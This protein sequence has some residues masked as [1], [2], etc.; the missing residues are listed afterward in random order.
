M[1]LEYLI[2]TL[3]LI[4]LV[5]IPLNFIYAV[6]GYN[7]ASGFIYLWLCLIGFLI[8][9]L[10]K[11]KTKIIILP[12]II[13]FLPL[14]TANSLSELIYLFIYCIMTLF[15][16]LRGMEGIR[17]DTELDLFSKGLYIC[18]ATCA[19]S[20]ITGKLSVF[21]TYSA[22]YV[23][24]YLVSSILLLRNL[25]FMEYNKDSRE[26]RRINNRYSI[27]IVI[28]SAVLSISY[29]REFVIN[30]IKRSYIYLVDLFMYLF[31]WLFL[32]IGYL[33]TTISNFIRALLEKL[34]VVY[35]ESDISILPEMDF[36]KKDEREALAY[37]LI[38]NQIFKIVV[39][40]FVILLVLYIIVRI[41][42]RLINQGDQQE[43][44]L[45]EKEFISRKDGDSKSQGKGF[46]DFLKPRNNSEQIRLLYQQ[47]MINCLQND[48]KISE[49]DT[50][51]EISSKAQIKYNKN[52]ID[53]L[54]NIYIKIRYGEKEATDDMVKEMGRHYKNI[55]KQS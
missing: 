19:V 2:K 52:L 30:F 1:K 3:N 39:K 36:A 38:N 4:A 26:G 8:N 50:T 34:G 9:Y 15:I 41:L 13:I 43:E 29:I 18:L 33:L 44:Y 35:N 47:Y 11:Q 46:F 6:L 28:F 25:R 55:R 32:G 51:E 53:G 7:N 40:A 5:F 27:F 49:S 17:Y 16:V 14:I 24:I 37:N 23:I 54:R 31:S 48:I 10:Y 12:I 21:S 45:E 22:Y 42:K 20:V